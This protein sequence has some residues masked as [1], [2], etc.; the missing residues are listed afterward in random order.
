MTKSVF[1]PYSC[2]VFVVLLLLHGLNSSFCEPSYHYYTTKYNIL[3]HLRKTFAP[4]LILELLKISPM[5]KQI[6]DKALL[7]SHVPN[8]INVEQFQ[9]MVGHLT[10]THSLV[11]TK[12]DMLT[13]D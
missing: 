5:H 2:V 13:N 6:L 8:A 11:F 9:A 10:S 12:K 3:D 7:E 4:I 1:V